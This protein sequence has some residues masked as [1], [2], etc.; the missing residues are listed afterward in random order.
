M[1]SWPLFTTLLIQPQCHDIATNHTN[2]R[3]NCFINNIFILMTGINWS[4]GM[5]WSS[6]M[7]D[8]W[9]LIL[10]H[11]PVCSYLLNVKMLLYNN[12]YI[13]ESLHHKSISTAHVLSVHFS[14]PSLISSPPLLLMARSAYTASTSQLLYIF[15][16]LHCHYL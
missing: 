2:S 12:N 4:P 9:V 10:I 14:F 11:L 8:G 13:L 6:S 1:H 5:V 3:S 15:I 7:N 16:E